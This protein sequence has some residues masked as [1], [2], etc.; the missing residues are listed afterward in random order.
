VEML[1]EILPDRLRNGGHRRGKLP[2]ECQLRGGF[3]LGA[4]LEILRVGVLDRLFKIRQIRQEDV[5]RILRLH[6]KQRGGHRQGHGRQQCD[7]SRLPRFE[8][9]M[10]RKARGEGGIGSEAAVQAGGRSVP[11]TPVPPR[12]AES[13][14]STAL[15]RSAL[16]STKRNTVGSTNKVRSDAEI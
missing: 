3:E 1:A 9:S 11:I 16:P 12:A 10:P 6:R 5:L 8:I 4:I 13:A 7:Q 2:V 14:P 15:G